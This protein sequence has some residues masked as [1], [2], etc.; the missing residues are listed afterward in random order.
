MRLL[1]DNT[2][3]DACVLA[4]TRMTTLTMTSKTK[5]HF[6][7]ELQ[8]PRIFKIASHNSSS[9]YVEMSDK[10]QPLLAGAGEEKVDSS[11]V[12]A[13]ELQIV[14]QV[15]LRNIVLPT[16]HAERRQTSKL[17]CHRPKWSASARNMDS[18]S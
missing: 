14:Q 6:G 13:E 2:R 10:D 17:V 7:T 18:T 15:C 1:Y 3:D 11:A 12:V 16:A 4:Y 8:T 5:T 9:K